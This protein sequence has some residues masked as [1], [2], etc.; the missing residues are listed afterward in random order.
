MLLRCSRLLVGPQG[1]AA[2]L[3]RAP[4]VSTPRLLASQRGLCAKAAGGSAEPPK[5]EGDAAAAA[6][7]PAPSDEQA[8]GGA[9]GA[10]GGDRSDLTLQEHEGEN[11]PPL[12]FEPGVAGAAQKGVSAIV[13]AFG[14]AA[15]GAIGWGASEA[16]FPSASSTQ[17]IFSEAF[18]KVQSDPTVAYA[19]GTPL[20]AYGADYGSSRGRRNT[21]ERWEQTEDGE[22]ISLV[23]FN[24]AGPQGSGGV[25]AQVPRKR[26][27]GEFG[28]II[29]EEPRSRRLV[30]V[31]D[32][33]VAKESAPPPPPPPA[34]AAEPAA[35]G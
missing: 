10:G 12:A 17:T 32:N 27:R 1:G 8:G 26:R 3:R 25:L 14:A 23:Q 35:A 28:Y 15:L 22:E 16:F 30:H 5:T 20:R 29:F 24:V 18:E 9:G 34:P 19:L 4:L 6:A 21:L 2:L 33:R 13:I 11:L 7:S 31:L